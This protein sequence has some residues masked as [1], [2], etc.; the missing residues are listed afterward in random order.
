MR[1][2]FLIFML[3]SFSG[4]ASVLGIPEEEVSHYKTPSDLYD[5]AVGYYESGQYA[6]A[7]DLFHEYVG[8]YPESKILKIAVYYLGHCYQMLGDDKEALALYNR[9]VTTYGDE[10][11]WGAQAMARIK[12]IKGE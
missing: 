7:R 4:C 6:K 10:D 8:T 11:F 9:V 3:M 5:K 2:L 1:T 12:Q